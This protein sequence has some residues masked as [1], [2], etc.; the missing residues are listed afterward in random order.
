ME[1][2]EENLKMENAGQPLTLEEVAKIAHISQRLAD[3]PREF[4]GHLDHVPTRAK[5]QSAP[6]YQAPS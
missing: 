2:L 5:S 3:N 1:N 6:F 4:L